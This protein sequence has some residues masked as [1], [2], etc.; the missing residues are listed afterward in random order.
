MPTL[1]EVQGAFG[2]SLLLG[3]DAAVA[4]HVVEDG[5][6]ATERLAIYRNTSRSVLTEALRLS[7]PAVDRLVGRDFFD[8]LSA[9]FI[10]A[11]PPRSGDLNLYGVG[12]ADVIA[13]VPE[14][15]TLAYLPDV[16]R[17]EWGLA[18]AANAP[19]GPRLDPA[20][21][22][23][24]IGDGRGDG[25]GDLII[26]PHASLRLLHLDHPA[27]A[28]AD[29]VLSDD[30]AALGAV[31]VTDGPVWLAVHRG[32]LGVEAERLTPEDWRCLH[33]L[34]GGESLGSLLETSDRDIA[35]LLAGQFLKGRFS[36]IRFISSNG[37]AVTQESS[38]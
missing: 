12:F 35:G 29:A 6:T 15:A 2:R 11:Q 34:C 32:P 19:D 25:Q 36:A 23:G 20:A 14:A 31:D 1:H 5:F 27:D 8:L 16:A 10:R 38:Q 37:S 26:E 13:T 7:H 33:R 22:A 24:A 4:V 9:R 3:E 18:C 30:D 28:I 17:F 21:F